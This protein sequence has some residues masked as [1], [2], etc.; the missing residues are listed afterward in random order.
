MEWNFDNVKYNGKDLDRVQ[1]DGVTVWEKAKPKFYDYLQNDG[2]SFIETN[3]APKD[4]D[5]FYI[6]ATIY[7]FVGSSAINTILG[8]RIGYEKPS[9]RLHLSKSPQTMMINYGDDYKQKPLINPYT[10][11]SNFKINFTRNQ[12]TVTT[13]AG[14]TYSYN[15][16]EQ[17]YDGCTTS[18]ILFSQRENTNEASV[19]RLK[20][21]VYSLSFS[22]NGTLVR[23]FK[24]CLYNGQAGLWDSVEG[25]FY[26]NANNKGTL[27]VGN[28]E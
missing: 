13:I 1:V 21:R 6:D 3:I 7:D 4:I 26:G 28:D 11:G 8:M 23:D 10:L 18:M 2:K 25:K 19:Y 20:G 9:L 12:I 5:E 14:G 15:L 17:T 24:P 22:N 16:E 27:T